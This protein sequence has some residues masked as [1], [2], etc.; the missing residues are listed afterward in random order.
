MTTSNDVILKRIESME[1]ELAQLKRQLAGQPGR[2]PIK[3]TR[4]ILKGVAIS[5]QE[6]EDAKR[7]WTKNVDDKDL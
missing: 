5:D 6:V 2:K 7:I 4:G 1:A 3:T